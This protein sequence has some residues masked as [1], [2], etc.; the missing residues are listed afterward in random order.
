M[1]GAPRVPGVPGALGALSPSPGALPHSAWCRCDRPCH[2][3]KSSRPLDL[4]PQVRTA[5]E[6]L[7]WSL[8]M[9]AWADRAARVPP[10]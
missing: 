5:A 1:L 9:L 3:G 7:G 4:I 2:A 10:A 8:V 6:A